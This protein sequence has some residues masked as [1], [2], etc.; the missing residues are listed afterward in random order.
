LGEEGSP[1]VV[2]EVV[3]ES[4]AAQHRLGFRGTN[5]LTRAVPCTDV[6]NLGDS[7]VGMVPDRA[8]A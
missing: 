4:M 7:E 1:D 2:W 8:A 6:V 5:R 3:E